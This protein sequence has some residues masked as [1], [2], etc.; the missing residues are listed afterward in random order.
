VLRLERAISYDSRGPGRGR[1]HEC[2]SRASATLNSSVSSCRV[3]V[4]QGSRQDRHGLGKSRPAPFIRSSGPDRH[5][6]RSARYP[7]Q[8]RRQPRWQLRLS[9]TEFPG[10]V[11]RAG[12]DDDHPH[13]DPHCNA[14][15]YGSGRKVRV[16][17][18]FGRLWNRNQ[19]DDWR[20]TGRESMSRQEPSAHQHS[21]QQC[22]NQLQL[23]MALG[24][25]NPDLHELR[26]G[27]QNIFGFE[28]GSELHT[29]TADFP[30]L[31]H[32]D[33]CRG[34]YRSF[35]TRRDW[36]QHARQSGSVVHG[37]LFSTLPAHSL[38]RNS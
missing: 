12:V 30:Q 32:S 26:H 6:N 24:R 4:Q 33:Q 38:S 16:D 13:N 35:P 27:C 36:A 14:E 11:H 5:H 21:A 19:S 31:R 22:W 28:P 20:L 9:G 23:I 29:D 18:S 37:R 17:L 3:P 25:R 8:P 2:G 15:R 7:D 1:V 34:F 10:F